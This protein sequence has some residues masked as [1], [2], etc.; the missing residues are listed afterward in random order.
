MLMSVFKS[1]PLTSVRHN[2]LI[3]SP[4]TNRAAKPRRKFDFIETIQS[5]WHT[6]S[7]SR[8]AQL[9][10]WC[11][12]YIVCD[13]I[14]VSRNGL[15]TTQ[16]SR[17]WRSYLYAKCTFKYLKMHFQKLENY[18]NPHG[19]GSYIFWEKWLKHISLVPHTCV[20]ELG[21]HWFR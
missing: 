8:K 21:Q 10:D 2:G 3:P 13:P 14:I 7:F 17:L 16:T 5:I 9:S 4:S 18:P 20:I 15:L 19:S 1:Y 6:F 11:I 12:S